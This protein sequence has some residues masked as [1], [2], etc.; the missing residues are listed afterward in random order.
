MGAGESHLASHF[1]ITTNMSLKE[2]GE[3]LR[4]EVGRGGKRRQ[5]TGTQEE[6][7]QNNDVGGFRTERSASHCYVQL[8][9]LES[10][11]ARSI[12]WIFPLICHWWWE[13]SRLSEAGVVVGRGHRVR[14]E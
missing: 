11:E 14:D 7:P 6:N 2:G 9:A 13:E 1:H 3:G 12:L 8:S 4:L 5:E 10:E